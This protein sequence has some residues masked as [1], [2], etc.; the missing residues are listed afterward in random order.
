MKS[1]SFKIVL[2]LLLMILMASCSGSGKEGSSTKVTLKIGTADSPRKLLLGV[3]PLVTA[4]NI[5]SV[6]KN[7]TITVTAS[8][9]TAISQSI[10][11]TSST[12]SLV[13]TFSVPNGSARVITVTG[14]DGRG[15]V[16]FKGSSAALDLNGTD[17][18]VPIQMVE[19][20]KAAITARLLLYFQD[21]LDYR[22]QAGTLAAA[23]VDPFYVSAGT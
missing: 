5:P 4:S 18:S 7:I 8:D 2:F 12:L 10:P 13:T 9:I 14:D 21:T 6:V 22:I 11:V 15:N 3:L 20:I 1:A 19:D 23:D 17:T 16:S